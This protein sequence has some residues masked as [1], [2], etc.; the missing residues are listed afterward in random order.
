MMV[1]NRNAGDVLGWSFQFFLWS[2]LWLLAASKTGVLSKRDILLHYDGTLYYEIEA[3]RK[4]G[5]EK[6]P[7]WRFGTGLSW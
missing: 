6:L 7:I 3:R 2:G 5:K 1:G 4:H